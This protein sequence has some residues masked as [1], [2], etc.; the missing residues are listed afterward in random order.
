MTDRS[1]QLAVLVSGSGSTLQNLIDKISAGELNATIGLVIG[2]RDALAAAGRAGG[3]GLDYQVVRRKDFADVE[4]F[5]NEM[6]SRCAGSGAE[7]V[8]CAGWLSLLRIPAA[9]RAKVVNVHPALLPSF[10]GQG[11][12]GEHVHRAVIDHGCKVSGCTVHF[13]DDH[14]DNGPIIIQQTCAVLENDTPKSLAERVQACERD[15]LPKAIRLIAA[16]RVA[17]DGR[18]VRVT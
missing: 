9:W 18:R 8:V 5:S 1:I 12:F 7:L 15:A 6:F 10:G 4:A 16:G 11:M 2:S 3:A 14:Y 13:V 17:V